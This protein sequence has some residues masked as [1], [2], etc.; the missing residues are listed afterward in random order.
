VIIDNFVHSFPTLFDLLALTICIG[1]LSCRIWVLQTAGYVSDKQNELRLLYDAW[2]LIGITAAMLVLSGVI[3]IIT[4]TA[5]MSGLPLSSGLSH[6]PKVIFKTHYGH[7]WLIRMTAAVLLF[8]FWLVGRRDIYARRY[9]ICMLIIGAVIAATRSASGHGADA[10][11]FSL[12]E[13]SDWLHLM[14]ASIWGGGL[15]TLSIIIFPIVLRQTDGRSALIAETAAR[16][17]RLAVITLFIILVTAAYNVWFE[18]G[19]IEALYET[20]YG[21]IVLSKIALLL[22]LVIVGASN[23]YLSIPNIIGS[24]GTP[25]KKNGAILQFVYKV[26]VEAVLIAALLVCTA[27]LL[28]QKPAKTLSHAEHTRVHSINK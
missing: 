1:A 14:A 2:K 25:E 11:D 28:H 7:V 18:V 8:A 21:K 16:F 22:V 3:L 9:S 6:I 26:R 10:G 4:R 24:S 13:I 19:S 12:P 5:E 27:L 15:I 20:P 23:R 17:T